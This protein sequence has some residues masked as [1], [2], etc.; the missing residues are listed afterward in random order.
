M[1]ADCG[2]ALTDIV[3]RDRRVPSE[4]AIRRTI[5]RLDAAALDSVLAAW[6]W[7]RS[8]LVSQHRVIAPDG[9]T[10]RGAPGPR[11]AGELGAPHV[12][13]PRRH[14]AR[15]AG[16]HHEVQR[17]PRSAQ[18][19]ASFDPT[20]TVVTVDAMD[21]QTDTAVLI[22][23]AEPTAVRFTTRVPRSRDDDK[24]Q[25]LRILP[26]QSIFSRWTGRYVSAPR[27]SLRESSRHT[28]TTTRCPPPEPAARSP[29]SARTSPPP[30]PATPAPT[31]PRAAPTRTALTPHR[32]MRRRARRRRPDLL[33][34]R[35]GHG[36]SKRHG[37]A[38][39]K[40]H[41]D[42]H[43]PRTRLLPWPLRSPRHGRLTD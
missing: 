17:D 16:T 34:A 30:G 26:G 6:L 40:I 29:N 38:G 33:V 36:L 2:E 32:V 18:P 11:V 20:G 31:S 21:T 37:K 15:P 24:P 22:V 7:T 35:R 39:L 9:T 4:T 43:S 10:I 23:D 41:D 13:P 25:K 28:A 12:G 19:V 42:L 3:C 14:R 8:H 1:P 27:N 5:D